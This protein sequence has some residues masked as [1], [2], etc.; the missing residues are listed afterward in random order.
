MGARLPVA[1]LLFVGSL[2]AMFGLLTRNALEPYPYGIFALTVS[3]ALA[4]LPLLGELGPLLRAD[5]ASE[6]VGSQP[7]RPSELRLARVLLL[8]MALSA[9]TLASLVP[10]TLLSPGSTPWLER[11]GLLAGGLLQTGFL[12]AVLLWVQAAFALRAESVLV[13]LQ[14]VLLAGTLIGLLGMLGHLSALAGVDYP[15]GALLAYPPAWFA[16]PL[17][18]SQDGPALLAVMASIALTILTFVAAPFPPVSQGGS[19]RTALGLLLHPLRLLAIQLWVRREER[20]AFDLAYDGLPAEREFV[21]RTY[22]L[23]AVPLAFLALGADASTREGQGLYAILMFAPATYL[24][25]MLLFV[26]GTA[27]PGARYL[28]DAAPLRPVDEMQGALKAVAVR[29]L[30]PLVLGLGAMVWFRASPNLALRL[31]PVAGITA[32]WV[33][34]FLW[35]R[36][37]S[38]PVLSTPHDD[39]GSAWEGDLT[40]GMMGVALLMTLLALLAWLRIPSVSAGLLLGGLGVLIELTFG[41]RQRAN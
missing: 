38:S 35:T 36:Y 11:L 26:P 3:L 37:V 9:L 5:P 32:L 1:P 33:L 12:A 18:A 27:T 4:A 15:K 7:V 16:L 20:A 22:P 41:R 25:A 30:L 17:A 8:A 19:T 28:L 24:P 31:T 21:V 6:W 14:A 13:A 23:V 10:L 40:G 34:R 29:F 2:S 39:L